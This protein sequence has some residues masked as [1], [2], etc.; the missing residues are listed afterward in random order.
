MVMGPNGVIAGVLIIL[1]VG[2]GAAGRSS[3]GGRVGT[4]V[5]VGLSVVGVAGV[6]AISLVAVGLEGEDGPVAD[7]VIGMGEPFGIIDFLISPT[8]DVGVGST[9]GEGLG[10]G[11]EFGIVAVEGPLH[12]SRPT[13][14]AS[15]ISFNIDSSNIL[16]VCQSGFR[17]D[18]RRRRANRPSG[19]TL[20]SLQNIPLIR[21][22]VTL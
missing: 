7:F 20:L 9:A 15:A 18:R 4:S 10:V 3:V 17:R 2:V 6:V 19:G 8:A 5:A 1:I 11:I 13:N 12:P 16:P 14:N 21:S 22:V